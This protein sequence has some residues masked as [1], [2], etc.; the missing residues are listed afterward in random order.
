MPS[1]LAINAIVI[2]KKELLNLDNLITILT[3]D[4]GKIK[5]LAKGIKKINSRRAP[6]IQTANFIN[7]VLYHKYGRYYLQESNMISGFSSIKKSSKKISLVYYLFSVI[8]KILPENQKEEDI[9]KITINFLIQLS[10]LDKFDNSFIEKYMN[11]I[12]KKLGYI[13]KNKT[14]EEIHATIEDII[15]KKLPFFVI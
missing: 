2:K 15:G 11:L 14:L 12:I 5:I 8:D 4:F 1:K 7:I 10:K 6:H 13:S 9:Y 3:E